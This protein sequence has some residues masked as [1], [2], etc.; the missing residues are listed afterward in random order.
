MRAYGLTERERDV[1]LQTIR[2]RSAK[3]AAA[4]LGLSA[5]TVVDHLRAVFEKVGVRS[6]GELVARIFFE[7]YYPGLLGEAGP[8]D[9]SDPRRGP[10]PAR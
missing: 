10:R 2:S 8:A 7:H 3:E 1:L 4:A 6:K 9:V 5:Y